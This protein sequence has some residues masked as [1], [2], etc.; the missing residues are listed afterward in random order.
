MP[1]ANTSILQLKV[2]LCGTRPPIWRRVLVPGNVTLDRFHHILQAVMGWTDSHLHE[3]RTGEGRYGTPD[4]DWDEDNEVLPERQVRLGQLLQHPKDRLI[5]EYDFGDDWR[6]NILLE[7]ILP[8][9]KGMKYPYVLAGKRAC[10]PEDVGGIW[11]YV[12][13]LEIIRDPKHPEHEDTLAWCGGSFDSEA[14]DA[15]AI[16]RAFHGG[17]VPPTAP[18]E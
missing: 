5:Y 8:Q 2:V 15:A 7:A 11:G 12:D 9:S 18:R 4:P 16:N 14:F 3:F 1:Q 10:P 17:W 6:H 13:F